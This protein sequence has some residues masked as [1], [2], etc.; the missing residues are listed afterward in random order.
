[1]KWLGALLV[2]TASS[3]IGMNKILG[4]K[5]EIQLAERLLTLIDLIQREVE[6]RGTPLIEIMQLAKSQKL[7]DK[8]LLERLSEKLQR[9]ES[10]Y[11]VIKPMIDGL[12]CEIQ[13]ILQTL[14]GVLGRYDS[15]TQ[16]KVC[17]QAAALMRKHGEARRSE[18]AIKGRIYGAVPI[19]LGLITV[20]LVF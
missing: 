3:W 14:C 1:M 2:L 19:T 5:R 15:I 17:A 10:F 9:G 8:A 11:E 20:M 4:L 13:Q 7:L 16:S 12:P 6:Q 18:L